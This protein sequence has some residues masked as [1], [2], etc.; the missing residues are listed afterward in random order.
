[1]RFIRWFYT[2][3]GK[4]VKTSRVDGGCE[5]NVNE[6]LTQTPPTN[7]FPEREPSHQKGDPLSTQLILGQETRGKRRSIK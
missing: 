3:T 2:Q 5:F 7:N 1:M 6:G 4:N